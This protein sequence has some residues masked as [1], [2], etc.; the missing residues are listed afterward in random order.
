MKLPFYAKV[1]VSILLCQLVGISGVIGGAGAQQ[2][3]YQNLVVPS[4]NPPGWVFGP[5]WTLLYIFM[6]VSLAIIWNSPSGKLKNNAIIIFL[7][8][9][10]LNGLWSFIF[11]TWH[12]PA[13]ALVDILLLL[14]LIISTTV[15]F[16]RINKL[17]G[18]LLVPYL[19]WVF[20]ATILNAAIV[21]LN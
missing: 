11:F 15:V 20:F 17:A 2:E 7:I 12:L 18:L 8:Q 14:I 6:G 16:R 21:Y 5:V 3:W 13:L 19:A 4:F 10:V 1:I 9:L